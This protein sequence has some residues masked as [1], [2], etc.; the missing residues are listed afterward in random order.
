M[1]C[2]WNIQE[3]VIRP[4]LYR[5]EPRWACKGH[6]LGWDPL[7]AWRSSYLAWRQ[8]GWTQACVHQRYVFLHLYRMSQHFGPHMLIKSCTQVP[9]LHWIVMREISPTSGDSDSLGRG[10]GVHL[11]TQLHRAGGQ[12]QSPGK[13]SF[14]VSN[15]VV[16]LLG[17]FWKW[18]PL[19][20]MNLT[21]YDVQD[22]FFNTLQ[23]KYICPTGKILWMG[24]YIAEHNQAN[25]LNES[26]CHEVFAYD[27]N[28]LSMSSKSFSHWGPHYLFIVLV[29]LQKIWRSCCM[30]P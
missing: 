30:D 4:W 11:N 20:T 24:K 27:V 23:A 12:W 28:L 18:L 10:S 14:W 29:D 17:G 8:K 7:S 22:N 26:V 1:I 3:L 6:G 16:S 9:M 15:P 21:I 19:P 5:T 25:K 2:S 13:L